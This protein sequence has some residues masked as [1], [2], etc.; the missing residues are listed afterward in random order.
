MAV[1]TRTAK[2]TIDADVKPKDPSFEARVKACSALSNLAIGY[3]NKI[4]MFNYPG[5]VESI[6]TVIRTDKAEARTKACSILWSFAAEMK[7]Q[8]PVVRRGDI[9]PALAESWSITDT[10]SG[11]QEYSFKLRQNVTFHD[12]AEWNCDVAKMN[13]DHVLA[14]ALVEPVWH[15][16]Y[17]VP[18]FLS[19]WECTGDMELSM[20]TSTK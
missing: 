7:N 11:G 5:F 13:L 19:G 17:G 3:D 14:G 20:T 8:V 15:G 4:P 12:G 6:L 10:P 16:W 18:K 1:I 2:T 9:L